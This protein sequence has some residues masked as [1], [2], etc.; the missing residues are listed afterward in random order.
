MAR[1]F[2]SDHGDIYAGG[3]NDLAEVNVEPVG[4]HEHVAVFEIVAD[5]R[6]IDHFLGLIRHDHHDHIG[7][8]SGCV[9]GQ[10]LE[11]SGGGAVPR[12]SALRL[13][14]HHFDSAIAEV[15]RMGM[16]LTSEA[17]DSNGL[18]L[19]KTQIGVF[20]VQHVS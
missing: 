8:G 2:G 11:S 20:V 18:P 12:R 5:S 6:L 19:E 16:T 13:G 1:A 4:E 15:L 14:H 10:D 3:R 9:G 17:Y 7:H